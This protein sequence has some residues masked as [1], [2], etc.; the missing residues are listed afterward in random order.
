M[1]AAVLFASMNPGLVVAEVE[2]MRFS[3]SRN[4]QEV[5]MEGRLR[6]EL[7]LS[8]ENITGST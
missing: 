4:K 7:R 2:R 3:T 6:S 1:A 5:L 8:Q